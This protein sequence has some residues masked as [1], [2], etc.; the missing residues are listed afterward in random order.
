M[1]LKGSLP[2]FEVFM[3]LIE[4]WVVTLWMLLQCYMGSQPEDLNLVHYHVHKD[5]PLVP[6]WARWIHRIIYLKVRAT[7]ETKTGTFWIL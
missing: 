6:I 5:L 2:C 1:E 7:G 4:V 3:V